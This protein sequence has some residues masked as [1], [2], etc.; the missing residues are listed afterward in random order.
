MPIDK[1]PIAVFQAAEVAPALDAIVG[2]AELQVVQIGADRNLAVVVIKFAT[3]Q[4]RVLDGQI[5]D[6]FRMR[7][8][9]GPGQVCLF[10]L[11]YGGHVRHRVV[12]L[13]IVQVPTPADNRQDLNG[14]PDAIDRKQRRLAVR[15]GA[16][17]HHA[18]QGGRN[19]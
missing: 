13:Y 19:R 15:A 12:D 9:A 14:D 8:A 4:P 16:A 10:P 6:V 17:H 1:V 3:S 5:E 7:G 18:V 11:V 2:R